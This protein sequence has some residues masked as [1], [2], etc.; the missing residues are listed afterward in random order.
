MAILHPTSVLTAVTRWL[1]SLSPRRPVGVTKIMNFV[2]P[3]LPRFQ[4]VIQLQGGLKMNV[5]SDNDSERGVLYA[6][7]KHRAISY[8]YRQQVKPGAYCIDIG[9]NV[10]FYTLLLSGLAGESGHVA[11]FEASPLMR[12]RLQAN[13]ALNNLSQVEV[14]PCAVNDVPGTFTFYLNANPELSSIH[15]MDDYAQA[16]EV[17]AITID[18]FMQEQQWLRLDAI[19]IDIEGNDCQAVIGARETLARFKPLIV[20][21]YHYGADRDTA[22]ACFTMLQEYGYR[23]EGMILRND[24]RFDFD[25]RTPHPASPHAVEVVCIPPSTR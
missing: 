3:H 10:G 9:A 25:W 7:D 19:K 6:G 1:Q 5:D 4:G 23:L 12:E 2:H 16:I 15:Q 11:A 17:E 8:L 22:D 24:A 21:E 14:V 18:Q 20:M 13:I